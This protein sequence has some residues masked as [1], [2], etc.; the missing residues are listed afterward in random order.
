MSF[1]GSLM[2]FLYKVSPKLSCTIS[3]IHNRGK[4]PNFSNPQNLS[5]IVFA[6]IRSKKIY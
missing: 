6:E 4:M 2:N 5:E 3:Y 1:K